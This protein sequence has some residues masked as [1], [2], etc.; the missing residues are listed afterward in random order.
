M[1][2]QANAPTRPKK[3]HADEV[4]TDVSLVRRLLTAQFPE[5]ADLPITPVASSGTDNAM[6]RLG[7][8]M[9][10]RLPRIGWVAGNVAREQEWPPRLAPHLPVAIPVPLGYGK[11]AEGYPY[12]WSVCRWL[13]GVN[14]IV[15]QLAEPELLAEDLAEFVQAIRRVDPEG[16]PECGRGVP[17]AERDGPTREALGQLHGLIDVPA[18]TKV[19][20][21]AVELPEWTGPTAWMHG[22]LSPGNVLVAD[23]RLKAVIDLGAVGVGDPTVDLMVAWNLLPANARSVFRAALDVDDDT[24]LR[25]RG[26][27]LSISLIQLPYYKDTNPALAENSRHVINEV[28]RASS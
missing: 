10:V 5:W 15:G 13:E 6:F 21:A 19:W 22:D 4:H 25:G 8:D 24:W 14:P 17:L 20:D 12:T 16:A 23:G 27:A 26:W 3:M 28:M 11:P 9:A 2:D 1:V 7:K 18:V